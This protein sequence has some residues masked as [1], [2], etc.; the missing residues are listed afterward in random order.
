MISRSII[1]RW[2]GFLHGLKS[3][4]F[5]ALRFLC[6]ICLHS[7]IFGCHTAFIAG[8]FS[9]L[10]WLRPF[11]VQHLML[12]LVLWCLETMV[13]LN[14]CPCKF[15]PKVF[16]EVHFL[17]PLMLFYHWKILIMRVNGLRSILWLVMLVPRKGQR[18]YT[19]CRAETKLISS[20]YIWRATS[21]YQYLSGLDQ[22]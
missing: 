12:V 5:W 9:L 17:V 15:I 22:Q 11:P 18:V 10:L 20:K 6:T 8:F 19:A 14:K 16:H 21:N 7:E 4:W 3:W 13:P 1:L 2:H